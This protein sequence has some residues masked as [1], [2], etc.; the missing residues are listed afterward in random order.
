MLGARPPSNRAS[1]RRDRVQQESTSPPPGRAASALTTHTVLTEPAAAPPAL[2]DTSPEQAPPPAL[3]ALLVPS[4]ELTR[5][6]VKPALLTP[7]TTRRELL[8]ASHVEM[9]TF[10]LLALPQQMTVNL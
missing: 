6:L 2:P 5:D 7:T 9:V 3:S 4:T 10:L 1:T 8:T